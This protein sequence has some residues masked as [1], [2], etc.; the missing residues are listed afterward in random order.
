MRTAEFVAPIV[1]AYRKA[2]DAYFDDPV[3][4]STNTTLM[5]ELLARRVREYTTAQTFSNP[6]PTGIDPSG[7][8]EP[9]FFSYESP[10]SVLTVNDN[11]DSLPFKSIP[12]LIVQVSDTA[13]AE[14]ALGAGADAVYLSGDGLIHHNGKFR[15]EWLLD[16]ADSVVKK[17]AR[18]AVMMPHICD[19]QDMAEWKIQLRQLSR[20]KNLAVGVSSI[21]CIQ[22]AREARFRSIIADFPMN[23]RRGVYTLRD[24]ANQDYLLEP[25][26]RCRNHIFTANDVCVLANLSR[27]ASLG[28]SL[29]GLSFWRTDPNPVGGI[30]HVPSPNCPHCPFSQQYGSCHFKCIKAVETAIQSS[31]N[32]KPAAMFIE[33]VQG[34]GGIIVPPPEYFPRLRKTMDKY[35]MPLIADEVQTGFGRTG[36]MFAMENWGV[37]PDIITGGKALR[38][39]TPIGFFSTTDKIAASYTRPGASTFGGNPVTARAALKFLE[40]LQRDNLVESGAKLGAI[41]KDRLESITRQC[42]VIADVRGLGL[43]IGVEVVDG[44]DAAASEITD[45]ILEQMKDAGFFLGKTGP[46][47]N[48]LTFMPPLIIKESQLMEAVDAL[49]KILQNL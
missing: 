48:V 19:Q 45:M 37:I 22:L 13:S 39:A 15:L 2:V 24:A 16:F 8:R 29:T 5:D 40:V 4:Y 33:P 3:N 18:V 36:K 27:I 20:I 12:E 46:G 11:G 17:D 43:M 21:G 42:D 49:E 35:D 23:C 25:D 28:M 44:K 26:K 31:T 9:R 32:G 41:L 30:T 47:R 10:E 38:A 7:S 34:N 6:G 1:T 14:T